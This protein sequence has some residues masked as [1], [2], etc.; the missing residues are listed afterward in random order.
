MQAN[1]GVGQEILHM[2]S[3]YMGSYEL[4]CHRT[5]V[6]SASDFWAGLKIPAAQAGLRS[7][8]TRLTDRVEFPS[9]PDAMAEFTTRWIEDDP[10]NNA[11]VFVVAPDPHT[12]LLIPVEVRGTFSKGILPGRF[13]M[14]HVLLADCTIAVNPGFDPTTNI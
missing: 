3:P 7:T 2:A 12:D 4:W 9:L 8:A 11:R 1:V 10:M 5:R 6:T 13:V 14:A